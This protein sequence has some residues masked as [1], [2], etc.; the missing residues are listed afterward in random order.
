VKGKK[1]IEESICYLSL[2][3]FFVGIIKQL[4]HLPTTSTIL[5]YGTWNSIITRNRPLELAM[6]KHKL[7]GGIS[8]GTK[9]MKWFETKDKIV[10]IQLALL[11]QIHF[12]TCMYITMWAIVK[13]DQDWMVRVKFNGFCKLPTIKEIICS[14]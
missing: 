11:D 12:P 1:G 6:V 9:H 8:F 5:Y 3:Y 10:E 14:F 4:L 13:E 2:D 7:E